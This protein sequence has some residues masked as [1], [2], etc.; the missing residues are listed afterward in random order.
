M[1]IYKEFTFDQYRVVFGYDYD[2]CPDVSHLG[3]ISDTWQPSA[4]PWS[5]ER[6][7]RMTHYSVRHYKN[8]R[9]TQWFIPMQTFAEQRDWYMATPTD[10]KHSQTYQGLGRKEAIAKAK[11]H[12]IDD[13]DRL[14]HYYNDAWHMLFLSVTVY[15]KG[16]EVASDYLGG[17]ESDCSNEYMLD[18]YKEMLVEAVHQAEQTVEALSDFNK[19][20]L[21]AYMLSEV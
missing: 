8:E 13:Y 18:T 9:V 3:E 7:G 10:T 20:D 2:E 4:V 15:F 14:F 12:L 19:D 11:K 21:E 1:H 16:H 17:I 6:S 5:Y